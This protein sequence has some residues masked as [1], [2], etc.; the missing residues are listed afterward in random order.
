MCSRFTVFFFFG[1]GGGGQQKGGGGGGLCEIIMPV[2]VEV[3]VVMT[4]TGLESSCQPQKRANCWKGGKC[5][6]GK[7]FFN[8]GR[9]KRRP[10]EHM[11]LSS[12]SSFFFSLNIYIF[13]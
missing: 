11:F 5:N 6:K 4:V 10:K 3:D 9:I 1:G 13:L 8:Q 7:Q 2:Y 12:S